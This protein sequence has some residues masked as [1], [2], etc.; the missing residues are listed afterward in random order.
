MYY[1]TCIHSR[2]RA[3]SRRVKESCPHKRPDPKRPTSWV[4]SDLGLCDCCVSYRCV[5]DRFPHPADAHANCPL[6]GM[7]FYPIEQEGQDYQVSKTKRGGTIYA[8]TKCLY[9]KEG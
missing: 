3:H 5:H 9:K 6:C 7:S 4:L 8:H 2:R 1:E